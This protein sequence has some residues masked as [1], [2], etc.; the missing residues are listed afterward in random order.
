M[1]TLRMTNVASTTC[2]GSKQSLQ[3]VHDKIGSDNFKT[4]FDVFD[5]FKNSGYEYEEILS[6]CTDQLIDREEYL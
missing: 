4:A 2:I 6:T 5:S 3:Q 1:K